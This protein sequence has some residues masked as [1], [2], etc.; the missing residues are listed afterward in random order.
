[1]CIYMIFFWFLERLNFIN[2]TFLLY[3]GKSTLN[4]IMVVEK[5]NSYVRG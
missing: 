3:E 4:S 2:K 5:V 1:M